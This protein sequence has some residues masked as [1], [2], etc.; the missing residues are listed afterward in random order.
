MLVVEAWLRV[1]LIGQLK[2][3]IDPKGSTKSPGGRGPR[4]SVRNVLSMGLSGR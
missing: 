3:P 2:V 4:L 1:L